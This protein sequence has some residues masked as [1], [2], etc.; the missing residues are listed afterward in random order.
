MPIYSGAGVIP[1]II[2]DNKPHLILFMLNRGSLTDAGGRI[3]KQTSIIDTASRELFEESAGLFNISSKILDKN[4]VYIDITGYDTDYYRSY[5]IILNNFDI[6]YIDYYNSNLLKI[7]TEKYNP[8]S[9]TRG[10]YLISLDN[11]HVIDNHTFVNTQDNQIIVVSGRTS[12]IIQKIY[13]ICQNFDNF[14]DK[15]IKTV[16]PINI[17]KDKTDI[18]TYTYKDHKTIDIKDLDTFVS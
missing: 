12:K 18:T 16:K 15:I 14:Y 17:K 5:L 4:S 3:E 7:K 8:F 13:D 11:I 2:I 1:I 9:E 6:T 10:I